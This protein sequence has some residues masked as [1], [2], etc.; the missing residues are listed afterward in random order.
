MLAVRAHLGAVPHAAPHAT[1][2][3]PLRTSVPSAR[4][5]GASDC[6]F[7]RTFLQPQ[8]TPHI[9]VALDCDVEACSVTEHGQRCR[10][11]C[12]TAQLAHA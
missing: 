7:P 9:N 10:T 11:T 4:P 2:H 1:P 12:Q 8:Y 6:I 3:A 5:F